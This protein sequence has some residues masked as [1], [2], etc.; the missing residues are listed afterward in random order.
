MNDE[1]ELIELNYTEKRNGVSEPK[2]AERLLEKA[3]KK[4]QLNIEKVRDSFTPNFIK[5]MLTIWHEDTKDISFD[6]GEVTELSVMFCAF[7]II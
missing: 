1:Y 5:S 6:L 4:K 7:V 2:T 3:S